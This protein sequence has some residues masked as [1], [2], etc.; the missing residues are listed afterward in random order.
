V[1][2]DDSLI[3]LVDVPDDGELVMAQSGFGLF[4]TRSLRWFGKDGQL[5]GPVLS[6]DPIGRIYCSGEGSVVE[7]RRRRGRQRGAAVVEMKRIKARVRG[8]CIRE[9]F[10]GFLSA[11]RLSL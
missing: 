1:P 9:I 2:R 11:R 3:N 5:L 10:S 8:E 4:D 7:S 6:K